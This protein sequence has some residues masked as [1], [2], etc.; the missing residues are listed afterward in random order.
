[1]VT[2]KG[3]HSVP[4]GGLDKTP[5]THTRVIEV[6]LTRRLLEASGKIF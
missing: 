3:T 2:P 4:L 1:M 6:N 5:Q